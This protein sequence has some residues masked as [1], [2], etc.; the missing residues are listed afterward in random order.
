MRYI[1]AKFDSVRVLTGANKSRKLLSSVSEATRP[2]SSRVRKSIFDILWSRVGIDEKSVLDLFAGTG[3]LGIEAL[4]RGASKAWFV[5]Q[6]RSA[7]KVVKENLLRLGVDPMRYKVVTS[8][9]NSF[10]DGYQGERFDIAFLDPPYAFTN[11]DGLLEKVPAAIMVCET[12]NP[13]QPPSGFEKLL[14]R[15]YGTT[16]VT[17]VSGSS[18]GI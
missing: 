3:S 6:S 5:D 16:V 1:F 9:Y 13:I 4:S 12:G 15:K 7:I 17:L 10:L 11:W 8:T 2:T 14:E 18:S